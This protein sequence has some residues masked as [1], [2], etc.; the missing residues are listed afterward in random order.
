MA[1]KPGTIPS[2]V[3]EPDESFAEQQAPGEGWAVI[4]HNDDHND[5]LY[6]AALI[7]KATGFS[8]ERAWE[9]MMAAHTKG[10]SVVTITDKAEAEKISSVLKTGGLVVELK[11]MG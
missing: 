1:T 3:I 8:L 10:K 6:V 5:M 2:P 4:L 7:V 9:I 11:P